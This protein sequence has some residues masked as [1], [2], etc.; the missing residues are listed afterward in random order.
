MHMRIFNELIGWYGTAAIIGAYFLNS[1]GWVSTTSWIYQGLNFTG[2]IGIVVVSLAKKA[3]QPAALNV[4]WTVIALIALVK[5][6][7]S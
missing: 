4:I 7:M 6:L 1:F 3:Y 2:A 5:I